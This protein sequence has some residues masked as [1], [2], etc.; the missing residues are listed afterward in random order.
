MFALTCVDDRSGRSNRRDYDEHAK[1]NN[2]RFGIGSSDKNALQK[3]GCSRSRLGRGVTAVVAVP[4]GRG[5]EYYYY[6]WVP[7]IIII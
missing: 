7:I 4:C 6:R 5:G 1:H 3:S 2:E